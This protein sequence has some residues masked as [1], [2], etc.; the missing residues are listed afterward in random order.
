MRLLFIA[1]LLLLPAAALA[2]PPGIQV[3]D[4]WSRAMPAGATGVVYLTITDTGAPNA[5]TGVASPAATSAEL[6][7][8]INDNGVM[9]MRPVARLPVAPGKPATLRPGGYHI[10]LMGLKRT[11]VADTQF[12]VTLTF[13]TGGSVTTMAMVKAAGAAAGGMGG[14]NMQGMP[15]GGS[16]SK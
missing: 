13:A 12:P 10:M 11:L 5:L 1:A 6:H 15:M 14:M 4:V 3:Q 8:T 16:G 9:K 7:E 2:D